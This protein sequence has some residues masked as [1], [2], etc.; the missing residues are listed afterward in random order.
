MTRF[1]DTH[2]KMVDA[3]LAYARE[4]GLKRLDLKWR[5]DADGDGYM[6]METSEKP[7]RLSKADKPRRRGDE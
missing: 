7:A 3:I 6:S 4:Q 2:R 1:T 5:E